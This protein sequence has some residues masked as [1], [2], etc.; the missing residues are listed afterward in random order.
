MLKNAVIFVVI[1]L[2]VVSSD[3]DKYIAGFR[4]LKYIIILPSLILISQRKFTIVL[5]PLARTYI[6]LFSN[7]LVLSLLGI[8]QS[9][10]IGELV[11]YLGIIIVTSSNF[12]SMVGSSAISLSLLFYFIIIILNEGIDINID[13]LLLGEFS[14]IESNIVAFICPILFLFYLTAHKSKY[15][16]SKYMNYVFNLLSIKRI[17]MVSMILIIGLKKYVIKYRNIAIVLTSIS[18]LLLVY[19]VSDVSTRDSISAYLNISLGL[20]TMGRSTYYT[21]LIEGT[22]WNILNVVFGY[23]IGHPQSTLEAALG[24]RFLLH[25]DWLKLFME[26]GVIGFLVFIYTIRRL[27][28]VILVTMSIWMIT[29]NI[30]V[31]FPV[32]ILIQ[33]YDL[34]KD[35]IT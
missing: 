9:V 22:N 8:H 27:D 29:D 21:Y 23:G 1:F 13:G 26:Q 18:T 35:S 17:T 33:W 11:I 14:S 16:G 10:N 15:R 6:F 28:P 4:F 12:M 34:Q 20:L 31:Y 3:F 30:L 5:T 19:I 24:K 7:S 32:I 25:N 2:L